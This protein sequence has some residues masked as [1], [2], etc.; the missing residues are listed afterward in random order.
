MRKSIQ[1]FEENCCGPSASTELVSFLQ[2]RFGDEV[3]VRVFDLA[4]KNGRLPLPPS[5]LLKIQTEEC[6]PLL[7]VDG[8]VVAQSKLPNFLEAVELVRTGQ[9]SPT[10]LHPPLSDA[11]RSSR[12]RC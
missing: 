2:R 5:L 4:Q 8:V 11:E 10:S 7:L 12:R 1:L 3:D 6:L 9:P